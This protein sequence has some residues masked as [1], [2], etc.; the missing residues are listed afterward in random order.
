MTPVIEMIVNGLPL[1]ESLWK[2]SPCSTC[3]QDPEDAINNRTSILRW[4]PGCLGLYFHQVRYQLPLVIRQT[5]SLSHSLSSFNWVPNCTDGSMARTVFRQ[6][7]VAQALAPVPL[8]VSF[9][10]VIPARDTLL[11]LIKD[12]D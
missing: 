9:E 5:M 4:T 11:A 10:G 7:L 3:P 12:V 8:L 1:A 2:I 6:S